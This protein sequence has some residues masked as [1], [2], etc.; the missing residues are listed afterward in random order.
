MQRAVLIAL[1]ALAFAA[2]AAPKRSAASLGNAKDEDP[3]FAPRPEALASLSLGCADDD[4]ALARGLAFAFEPAPVEIRVIAIEDLALLGDPRALNPLAALIFD[5][6]QAVQGAALR[7][8][9]QFAAPR[10]EEILSNIV[11]HPALPERLKLQAVEALVFQRAPTARQMLASV[12]G[13]QNYTLGLRNAA[14]QALD[15]WGPPP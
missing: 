7:A 6:Q 15:N 9:S 2:S 12:A 1:A 4:A 8:V 13:S 14:R 10:A 3:D 5:S 11:R